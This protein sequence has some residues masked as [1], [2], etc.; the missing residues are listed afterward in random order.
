MKP[1]AQPAIDAVKSG[2]TKFVPERFNKI[3]FHW[4][5]NIKDWCISRQLWWG[6]Q[7]PAF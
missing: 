7:I 3:Y 4:L 2:K 1:L 6:H 5:E